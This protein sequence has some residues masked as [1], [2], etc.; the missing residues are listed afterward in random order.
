MGHWMGRA[1]S[2]VGY[3]CQ[4]KMSRC[5]VS[6]GRP[7]TLQPK[8]MSLLRVCSEVFAKPTLLR[9]PLTI[10]ALSTEATPP[11][12]TATTKEP[13]EIAPIPSKDVLSADVISG[14][15]GT[16]APLQLE[17]EYFDSGSL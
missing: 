4:N 15:P 12:P 11:A 1:G 3:I 16:A 9:T 13:S 14:A 5:R 8:P 6:R 2:A 10:R 7:S 17:T